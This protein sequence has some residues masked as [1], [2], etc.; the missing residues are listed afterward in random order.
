[1]DLERLLDSS[2]Y[3]EQCRADMILWGEERRR[4]DP[5]YFI[6]HIASTAEAERPLWV[7]SDARRRSD[8]TC[9]QQLYGNHRVLFVRI[10]A[11]METR[12]ARGW[13]FTPGV[14]DAES[15][16][17]L[18]SSQFDLVVLNEGDEVELDKQLT[19]LVDL[20]NSRL[21]NLH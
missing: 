13:K 18:D 12:S 17:D 15:E 4:A 2:D 19:D 1:L 3:K 11:S 10:E 20:A 6:R 21:V 9:F 8:V 5:A 7:I 16:C 14:D